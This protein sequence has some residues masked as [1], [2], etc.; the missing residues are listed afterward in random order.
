MR[1][2]VVRRQ[3]Y[4][5]PPSAGGRELLGEAPYKTHRETN[6]KPAGK[7]HAGNRLLAR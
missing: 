6:E 5:N 2:F 3:T 1:L 4:H 7:F